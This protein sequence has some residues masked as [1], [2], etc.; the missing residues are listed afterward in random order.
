M[1][2]RDSCQESPVAWMAAQ[3]IPSVPPFAERE[4]M[5]PG[6]PSLASGRVMAGVGSMTPE[7]R[8]L[9]TCSLSRWPQM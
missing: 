7:G 3:R 8:L 6:W 9:K 1:P 5:A 2:G 4:S